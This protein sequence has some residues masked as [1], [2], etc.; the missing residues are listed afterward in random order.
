M[1]CFAAAR[2]GDEIS[3][4][5]FDVI[6]DEWWGGIGSKTV[7][8]YLEDH[9]D[10]SRIKVR[11]N[12]PGGDVF[13]G[14]AIFNLLRAHKAK[15]HV[16]IIGLAASMASVIA[17]AGD[18]VEM[19]ENAMF[20]IHEPWGF[21]IGRSDDMRRMAEML[22]KV[23]DTILTAYERNSNLDRE[24]LTAMLATKTWMTAA[25]AKEAGFVDEVT[26]LAPSDDPPDDAKARARAVLDKFRR[27]PEGVVGRYAP[28]LAAMARPEETTTRNDTMDRDKLIAALGLPATATDDDILAA[29]AAKP[30]PAPKV[31]PIHATA[32]LEHVVPRSD[33]DAVKAQ[34]AEMK[35]AQAKKAREDFDRTVDD[36]IDEAVKAGKVTPAAKDYHRN[37]IMARA[38]V[39]LEEGGKALA[40]FAKYVDAQPEL[41]GNAQ[42][43]AAQT[44]DAAGAMSRATSS[45]ERKVCKALGIKPE[46]LK[47]TQREIAEDPDTYH[48]HAYRFAIAS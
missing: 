2:N 41:V 37:S 15:V 6:G 4:D 48:P 25:E 1:L 28:R 21:A 10:A 11:I 22:D 29:I 38:S 9:A 34:L 14:A 45:D 31:E 16:S 17:L 12:S 42:G 32:T 3:L 27:A 20:M 19:A 7:A 30:E 33:Y 39:S 46:E 40:E 43:Q 47:A 13:E 44:R 18:T 35:A 5:L 26:S 24:K 23:K 36:A 8:R